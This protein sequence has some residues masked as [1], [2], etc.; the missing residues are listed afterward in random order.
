MKILVTGAKGFVGRN[1]TEY[2]KTIRDGKN[3]L[4]SQLP[5]SQI[6]E[7]D[8]DS[9]PEDLDMYCRDA[10]YV[11]HL[12]GV[13]RSADEKE[14]IRGNID[15]TTDL[16]NSLIKNQNRCPVMFSSSIQACRCDRYE[17]S[18][19]GEAKLACEDLL[20][21]YK[22][23]YG[24]EVYVFR[25]PNVF[26]KW[27]RPNYNSVVATF[28][29]NIAR[30]LPIQINDPETVLELLY[31]DDLVLGM[32]DVLTGA[33]SRCEY[34]KTNV[35]AA[36]EG[37][38]CYI[39]CV[40]SVSL[41]KIAEMLYGF[42]EMQSLHMI[43]EMKN[44]SFE[45]K[46]YSTY[47]SYL[48]ENRI[49]IPLRMNKDERGSFTEL[50]KTAGHGQ[51]SVNITRPGITRGE[52]WHNSKCESFIVIS[53]HGLIRERR[54]GTEEVIEFEVDGED[55]HT[56]NMLPGYTHSIVN[57]SDKDDLITIIW[58]NE[59]FDPDYPDTYGEKV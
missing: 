55:F 49:S 1:L 9:S 54:I 14:L 5:I 8:A 12:A 32:T 13:N 40:Y 51:V 50:L 57:L 23:E 43:P 15:I 56:I 41:G 16:I 53:G 31:I 24:A 58:A 38:Y 37:K 36:K 35:I 22:E 46:L 28:C 4:Y 30:D 10:D 45:K 33:I 17:N 26:G 27:C 34:D 21:K 29:N 3:K 42:K 11:F 39:P 47:V 20:F 59:Q 7:Y 2:F 6:Y 52:H 48:P 18:L 25:F 19:Y 44:G